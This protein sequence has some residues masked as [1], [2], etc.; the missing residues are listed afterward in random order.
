MLTNVERL[1]FADKK[2]ALDVT[3]NGNTGKALEFIGA[4]ANN[5]I[6]DKGAVGS[7][8]SL[9]D[10][11]YSMSQVCQAAITAD[12][13]KNLAGSSSNMDLA[14]LVIK[15]VLGVTADAVTTDALVSHMDGTAAS[16]SQADFLATIAGLPVNEIHIGL[17]GVAQT[18]IEYTV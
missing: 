8:Q 5:L 13:I 3:N 15:N 9:F 18:G 16:L 12:L 1:Q 11:G 4:I 17:A 10:A 6:T 14:K 2:V 7:I